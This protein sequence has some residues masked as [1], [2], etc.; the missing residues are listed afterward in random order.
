MILLLDQLLNGAASVY[1]LDALIGSYVSG[2]AAFTPPSGG[3]RSRALDRKSLLRLKSGNSGWSD[4]FRPGRARP[5]DETLRIHH[6]QFSLCL[7]LTAE[8]SSRAHGSGQPTPYDS[9]RPAPFLLQPIPRTRVCHGEV[10]CLCWPATTDHS[11]WR[12]SSSQADSSGIRGR[13]LWSPANALNQPGTPVAWKEALLWQRRDSHHAGID[14]GRQ[15]PHGIAALWERRISCW[16][17]WTV[18]LVS[19]LQPLWHAIMR[20]TSPAFPEE[21]IRPSATQ[22]TIDDPAH[23]LYLVVSCTCR[24]ASHLVTTMAIHRPLQHEMPLRG[25]LPP[26]HRKGSRCRCCTCHSCHAR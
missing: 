18:S 17:C 22:S 5:K 20:T 19:L 13:A 25:T 14:D 11:P 24:L 7:L 3:R 23:Q 9:P 12:D 2:T 21:L 10:V 15:K 4:Q 1:H 16:L 6:D 8:R 26:Q